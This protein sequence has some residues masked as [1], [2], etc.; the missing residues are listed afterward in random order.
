MLIFKGILNKNGYESLITICVNPF[1]TDNWLYYDNINYK[2]VTKVYIG[3]IIIIG[4]ENETLMHKLFPCFCK[5][6]FFVVTSHYK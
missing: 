4:I 6:S 2:Y 1:N 5:P 3:E